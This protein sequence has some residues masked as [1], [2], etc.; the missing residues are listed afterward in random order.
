M[1]RTCQIL[2]KRIKRRETYTRKSF[3]IRQRPGE[4]SAWYQW[5]SESLVV[6]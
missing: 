3:L 2:L 4:V 1:L 5:A 6:H